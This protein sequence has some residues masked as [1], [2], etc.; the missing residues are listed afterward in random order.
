MPLPERCALSRLPNRC[1]EIALPKLCGSCDVC[2]G[3][4]N[5][6]YCTIGPY[7][8]DDGLQL[9]SCISA[10]PPSYQSRRLTLTEGALNGTWQLL[11]S[12][13]D[14]WPCEWR[15]ILGYGQYE[16]YPEAPDCTGGMYVETGIV[17]IVAYRNDCLLRVQ[18]WSGANYGSSYL[19]DNLLV[20]TVSCPEIHPWQCC[21]DAL[22]GAG[23]GGPWENEV[24]PGSDT[25]GNGGGGISL[26][27]A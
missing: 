17:Y 12:G 7:G 10:G 20:A 8:G 26:A 21:P 14:T 22:V 3:T 1:A 23:C 2:P 15:S 19:V 25:F 27:L 9:L 18:A 11:F 16:R 13:G 4:P 24:V 6:I 5:D